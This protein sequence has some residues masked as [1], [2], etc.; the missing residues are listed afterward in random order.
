M[1]E[2]LTNRLL[3]EPEQQ[4]CW[5]IRDKIDL[6]ILGELSIDEPW[7]NLVLVDEARGLGVATEAGYAL[8][9]LMNHSV[10]QSLGPTNEAQQFLT[11]LGFQA[12]DD[13]FQLIPEAL[14]LPDI[15]HDLNQQLGINTQKLTN[16]KHLTS[17]QLIESDIDCFN[18]PTRLNPH[19]NQAWQM[20]KHKANIDG[21][22]L[23]LASAF[24]S[25]RYQAG[26]IQRKLDGGELLH[27]ILKTNTAPGHSEHHTGR[28]IDIT[29]DGFEPLEDHFENSPAFVWL[30]ENAAQFGFVMSYP[31]DNDQG[32]IYEPWHWCYHHHTLKSS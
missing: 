26:L 32:I 31:K 24:R 17:C 3:I 28:A 13:Y 23:K 27:D 29:T 11:N 2:L 7:I 18:R 4:N 21:I 1:T 25:M 9:R 6:N 16:T 14:N 15:Y 20:M 30:T 5:V 22:D 12:K 10:F 19:A 8:L